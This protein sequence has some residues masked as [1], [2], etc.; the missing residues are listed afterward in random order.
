MGKYSCKGFKQVAT[1]LKEMSKTMQ[2]SYV[3]G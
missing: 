3:G 1:W 2:Y